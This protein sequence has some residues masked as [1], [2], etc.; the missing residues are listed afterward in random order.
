MLNINR[1]YHQRKSIEFPLVDTIIHP[2]NSKFYIKE[3]ETI[4][5]PAAH[6]FWGI[7]STQHILIRLQEL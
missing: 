4:A 7:C 1:K 3:K 5:I 6:L 2:I